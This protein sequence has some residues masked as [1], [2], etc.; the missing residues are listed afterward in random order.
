MP[1]PQLPDNPVQT[2]PV[3][4]KGTEKQAAAI[5]SFNDS[6]VKNAGKVIAQQAQNPYADAQPIAYD[7]RSVTDINK[8]FERYYSHPSFS[9]LGFNPWSDNESLYDQKGSN[10]GDVARAAQAGLKLAVTGFKAPLRSYADLFTGDALVSDDK[11][12]D[13][14]RYY[15]TVG[16]SNKGGFTGFTSNLVVNSGFTLG[17]MGEA[18]AEQAALTGLTALTGGGTSGAQIARAAKTVKDFGS[19]SKIVEGLSNAAS[20]LNSYPAAKIAYDSFKAVGKFL[21]P[22]ENT[23]NALNASENLTGLA[24]VSNTAAG[25][26]RDVSAANFT[27]SEAK[28]EGATAQQDLEQELIGDFK[29]KHDGRAPSY[30]ELVQIKETS[31]SAG[32]KTLAFNIPAIYLTNKITFA[33]LFKSFTR[34][35]EYIL[36]NGAKFVEKDGE[37][38]EATLRNTIKTALKPKNLALLPITYFKENTSEG[39]Q[40]TTQDIISGAAKKYYTDIYNSAANQ[41]LTFAQAENQNTGSAWDAISKGAKDQFSGKGF[42]TF[43]SGFFMGGLL[44]VAGAP[45]TAA[46]MSFTDYKKE[47]NA[48][49]QRAL[50]IGNEIYKDPLKWFAPQ[51]INFSSTSDGLE[52]QTQAENDD[53]QKKW[54]DFEDQSTWAHFTTALDTGTYDIA[55]DKLRSIKTMTPDAIKESYGMDGQQVLSKIDKVI[56]RAENLKNNYDNWTEKT[57]NPFNPKAF[58]EDTP[59]YN[60]E[61]ISF[62]SWEAAKK[63]AVFQEY[64]FNRNVDR[65]NDLNKDI[66]QTPQFKQFAPNDISILLDPRGLRNEVSLLDSEIEILG[67]SNV[68]EDRALFKQKQSKRDKLL[69]YQ[70]SL[71]NYYFTQHLDNLSQ[72]EKD[73]LQNSDRFK[74]TTKNQLKKSYQNYIKHLGTQVGILHISDPELNSSFKQILDIHDLKQENIQFSQAINVLSNPKG[75]TDHYKAL[76]DTFSDLYQHRDGIIKKSIEDTQK[77]IELNVGLLKPLYDRG[78]VVDSKNLQELIDEG[79]IPSQF[80]DINAKQVVNQSDPIRYGQFQE[81]VSNYKEATTSEEVPVE[82][83]VPTQESE[84]VSEN[85]EVP[86]TTIE[87]LASELSIDITSKFDSIKNEQQLENLEDEM[88]KLMAETTLEQRN[89]LGIT[90]DKIEAKIEGKRQELIGEVSLENLSPGNIVLLQDGTKAQITFRGRNSIKMKDLQNLGIITTVQADNL[91]NTIKMKYSENMKTVKVE[92]TPQEVEKISQNVSKQT[93]FTDNQENL[94]NILEEAYGDENKFQQDF[95]NDLGCK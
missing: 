61:A 36:K 46:R 77:K 69:D 87:P 79:T 71:Q 40:E 74:K 34:S 50:K 43:A 33:P 37:L 89:K 48:Y 64:S 70:Q 59:E 88:T 11:S 53:D 92:A 66:L 62:L 94:K 26:F 85:N 32:D 20:K 45:I 19:Y 57:S 5:Q 83:I 65:V 8:N 29:N 84:I 24:K 6:F 12:A 35:G 14:M 80:Y 27:L 72:E 54:N 75:F 63:S 68:P 13:E 31:K 56:K 18:I 82:P 86:E 22:L 60:K 91:K 23:V 30:D 38:V 67:D 49:T 9:K 93:K 28:V 81:I 4:V 16:S 95:L 44:R 76:F 10:I 52:N 58:I 17:F 90:S 15:N 41:G 1:D 25:F 73:K 78:F 55:L 42:E 2:P 21:N 47:K 7:P 51:S 39:I 3:P